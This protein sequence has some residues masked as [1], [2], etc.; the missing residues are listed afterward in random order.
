MQHSP[1]TL[2]GAMAR[3]E[4]ISQ[5]DCNF[6][7]DEITDTSHASKAE[8]TVSR[9]KFSNAKLHRATDNQSTRRRCPYGD[10]AGQHHFCLFTSSKSKF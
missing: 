1:I 6:L 3:H 8:E 10:S 7:C 4:N 2:N 5:R 9:S